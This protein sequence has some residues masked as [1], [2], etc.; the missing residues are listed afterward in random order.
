MGA[1]IETR[2]A[3]PKRRTKRVASYMGAWIETHIT[4]VSLKFYL[5]AS[6]MGAWIETENSHI[7]FFEGRSHPTWVRGLKLLLTFM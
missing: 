7:P 6:Y 1:W 4:S 2:V 5:V 3:R